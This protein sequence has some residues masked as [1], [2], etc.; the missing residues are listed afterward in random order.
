M[1][2]LIHSHFLGGDDEKQWQMERLNGKSITLANSLT[3]EFSSSIESGSSSVC[4]DDGV[5]FNDSESPSS[6]IRGFSSSEK[7]SERETDTISEES[8]YL[9]FDDGFT[10]TIVDVDSCGR[11]YKVDCNDDESQFDEQ[12]TAL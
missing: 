3:S 9:E 1:R 5:Q 4:S 12:V 7:R 10:N 2:Q 6:E 8:G 11:S